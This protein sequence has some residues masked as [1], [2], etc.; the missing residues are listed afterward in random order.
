MLVSLYLC[1][2]SVSVI[3]PLLR[4]E[5]YSIT[6]TT[7]SSLH[8]ACHLVLNLCI[9][10]VLLSLQLLFPIKFVIS[11]YKIFINFYKVIR[12]FKIICHK[13]YSSAVALLFSGSSS[14]FFSWDSVVLIPLV[15]FPLSSGLLLLFPTPLDV[16]F[17][18]LKQGVLLNHIL[19]W[20]AHISLK[21]F[22]VL[23]SMGE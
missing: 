3:W 8:Y 21:N 4:V 11:C 16:F 9:Y 1:L 17:L 22:Q 2:V 18:Y 15:F 6:H 12:H 20:H 7:A 10:W 5:C 13:L 23:R 19:L 14:R